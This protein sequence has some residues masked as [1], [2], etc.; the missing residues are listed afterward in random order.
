LGEGFDIDGAGEGEVGE[1]DAADA[2]I[3]A[4][5][6]DPAGGARVLVGDPGGEGLGVGEGFFEGEEG[7]VISEGEGEREEGEEE[8]EEEEV[9]SGHRR[10]GNLMRPG[11]K[12]TAARRD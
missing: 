8:E 3:E 5:D 9:N 4:D 10:A 1:M 2:I 7:L 12:W 11:E 6:A